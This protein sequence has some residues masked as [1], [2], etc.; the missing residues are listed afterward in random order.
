[1]A[2][3]VKHSIRLTMDFEFG[4][5]DISDSLLRKY[6]SEFSNPEEK[7][8]DPALYEK[9]DHQRKLLLPVVRDPATVK[10]LMLKRFQDYF[11]GEDHPDLDKAI[12]ELCAREDARFDPD[13]LTT[14]YV[15]PHFPQLDA[16]SR[17]FFEAAER[18][19][20]QVDDNIYLRTEI[21]AEAIDLKLVR[22]ELQ[23]H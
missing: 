16:S 11:Y 12:V 1:M 6:A 18:D 14:D 2:T 22:S 10:S 13:A 9:A 15:R 19:D 3:H 8:A 20:D 4:I 7:L 23:V 21:L 5:E 17:A